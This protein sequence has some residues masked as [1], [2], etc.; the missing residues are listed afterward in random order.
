M[1]D[2]GYSN[3]YTADQIRR[4]KQQRIEEDTSAVSKSEAEH[5]GTIESVTP[6]IDEMLNET[7]EGKIEEEEY[8]E[9]TQYE[10]D[11]SGDVSVSSIGYSLV[12]EPELEY[13]D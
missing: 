8:T 5:D 7:A 3:E 6:S 9:P 13:E 4:E 11:G 2:P 10:F 1:G 12:F